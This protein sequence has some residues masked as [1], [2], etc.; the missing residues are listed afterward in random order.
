MQK[1]MIHHSNCYCQGLVMSVAQS[2]QD[3]SLDQDTSK[4]SKIIMFV[5]DND[6]CVYFYNFGPCDTSI[7]QFFPIIFA[8]F[9][10]GQ[11]DRNEG[12]GNKQQRATSWSQNWAAVVR[13]QPLSMMHTLYQVSYQ[14]TFRS[15][16]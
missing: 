13:T 9:L 8:L 5:I 2:V 10:I 6:I 4:I 16:F 11:S 3:F 1:R 14:G 7:R 12:G 15:E